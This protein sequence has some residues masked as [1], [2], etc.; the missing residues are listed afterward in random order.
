MSKLAGYV[1]KTSKRPKTD[2]SKNSYLR[3]GATRAAYD[4][5]HSGIVVYQP[6]ITEVDRLVEQLKNLAYLIRHD[7]DDPVKLAVYLDHTDSAV[8]RLKKLHP[9]IAGQNFN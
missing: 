1:S 7:I 5:S 9:Q 3:A 2:W 4:S 8:A 6:P